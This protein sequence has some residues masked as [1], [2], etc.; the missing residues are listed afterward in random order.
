[1]GMK[2][3]N[4]P[5]QSAA[6]G[7]PRSEHARR[8]VLKATR[9]LIEEGGYP[10]ATIENIAARSGV[11]KTTIY[12]WWTNRPALVVDLMVQVAAE[13][14]PVPSGR[15]PLRALRK[16]LR[17]LA[18]ETDGLAGRLVVSLLG[19]AQS[20]PAVRAARVEG[21]FL[22]RTAADAS[23]I[24]RAQEAGVL[25]KDISPE[26]AVDLL[27]GPL[28]YRM[29]VHHH[30]VTEEFVDQMFRNVLTGLRAPQGARK[31][32]RAKR[33]TGRRPKKTVTR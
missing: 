11:A 6:R 3:T 25:R 32:K 33:P 8:A 1:M 15:D 9:S 12:R 28:F 16:E 17:T 13:D 5:V 22:P 2:K 7:R 27:F 20:D 14:V 18:G 23:M 21:L 29:F 19:E 26:L 30:P 4:S 24:R 10:A 31:S